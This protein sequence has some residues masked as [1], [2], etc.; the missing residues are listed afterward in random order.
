MVLKGV[1]RVI[2]LIGIGEEGLLFY[3]P[4]SVVG[5]LNHSNAS[6]SQN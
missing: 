2:R 1:K 4:F 3:I 6:P 5:F